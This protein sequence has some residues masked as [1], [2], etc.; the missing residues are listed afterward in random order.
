MCLKFISVMLASQIGNLNRLRTGNCVGPADG[1]L[2]DNSCFIGHRVRY[3]LLRL[4]Q[5]SRLLLRE[6]KRGLAADKEEKYQDGGARNSTCCKG[7]IVLL[8]FCLAAAAY[9][10]DGFSS[11]SSSAL[12]DIIPYLQGTER[13][14]RHRCGK[15]IKVI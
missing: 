4:V 13:R 9:D 10:Y 5:R 3:R 12:T 15:L 7:H 14:R 11:P 1:Y 2:S 8:F 6:R